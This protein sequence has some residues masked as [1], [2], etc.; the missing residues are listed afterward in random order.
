[1]HD[2]YLIA[3]AEYLLY[4]T[5]DSCLLFPISHTIQEIVNDP[6]VKKTLVTKNS[7]C[8]ETSISLEKD[9]RLVVWPEHITG[10]LQSFLKSG[11]GLQRRLQE[12]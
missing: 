6:V 12:S 2:H 10:L 4:I 1:M 9:T 8:M 7:S 5:A 11:V 3:G